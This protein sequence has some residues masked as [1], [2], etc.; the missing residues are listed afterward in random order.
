MNLN[1]EGVVLFDHPVKWQFATPPAEGNFR[2]SLYK[3]PLITKIFRSL[4]FSFH[5]I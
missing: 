4:I 2:L 1:T 5:V 3:K